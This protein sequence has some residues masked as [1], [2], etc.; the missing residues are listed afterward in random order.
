[1]EALSSTVDAGV[2]TAMEYKIETEYA[3]GD[4][5]ARD[6]IIN[7]IEQQMKTMRWPEKKTFDVHL[8]MEEGLVNAEKHG[9]QFDPAK[10][11]KV[12]ISLN[13]RELKVRIE[14][15][16]A[17]FD[18]SDVPDPTD[19]ENLDRPCG[20]GVMLMNHYMDSVEYSSKGNIV[21]MTKQLVRQKA[22]AAMSGS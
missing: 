6:G 11:V 15:E 16:G 8:A 10:K 4:V 12:S 20:R 14:D 1:M 7:G 5:A 19:I 22:G 17:G 9:N 2:E 18:P 3:S 21:D 13:D